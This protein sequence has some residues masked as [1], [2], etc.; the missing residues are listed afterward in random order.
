ME[1]VVADL[2]AYV[3][4]K[5]Q[6]SA[7]GDLEKIAGVYLQKRRITEETVSKHLPFIK[8]KSRQ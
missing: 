5:N 2:L 6:M 7:T 3:L 1:K 4:R 8:I